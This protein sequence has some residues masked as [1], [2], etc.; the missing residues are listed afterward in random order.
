LILDVILNYRQSR[1]QIID[2]DAEICGGARHVS[3]SE[4]RKAIMDIERMFRERE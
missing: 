4:Y 1:F 2:Q 3:N